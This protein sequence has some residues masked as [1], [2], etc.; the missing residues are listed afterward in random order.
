MVKLTPIL[1]VKTIAKLGIQIVLYYH[2]KMMLLFAHTEVD[3]E[4]VKEI[5]EDHCF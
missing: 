4:D 3:V 5:L 1:T 2:A